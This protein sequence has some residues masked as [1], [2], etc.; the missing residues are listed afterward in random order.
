MYA[1][2]KDP[3][4]SNLLSYLRC[5]NAFDKKEDILITFIVFIA[6]LYGNNTFLLKITLKQNNSKFVV[7]LDPEII[8]KFFILKFR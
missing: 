7:A 8:K 1:H 4:A 2:E 5:L 6:I 3:L